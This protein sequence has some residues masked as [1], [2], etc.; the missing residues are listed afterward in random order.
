MLSW[1][2]SRAKSVK[3]GL[4]SL[5][6]AVL[7]AAWAPA[8]QD[9]RRS[10][11]GPTKNTLGNGLTWI[12][13][14]DRSSS[15][16]SL[17]F[18]IGGGQAAEPTG[19]GGLSY[20][21]ARM[22]VEI[23]DDDKLRELMTRSTRFSVVGL[24]DCVLI[25]IQCLSGNL[26]D[27]LRTTGKIMTDPLI[28]GLRIDA[29]KENMRYQG[30]SSLDDSI[31]AGH[32]AAMGAFFGPGGCGGPVWG[33]EASLDAIR[34]KDV[35]EFYESRVTGSNIT[36]SVVSDLEERT[37]A[38][39]LEKYFA[40]LKAGLP[41]KP[42]SPAVR[43]PETKEI[44]IDKETGETYL[45]LAFPL[46]ALS[47]RNFALAFLVDNVLSGGIGSRLW[48]LRF[49][50][51]LA[52]S[53]NAVV[54]QTA[55]QGMLEAYL[56]TSSGKLPSAQSALRRV[57]GELAERGLTG[58]ELEA[59]VTDSASTFLRMNETKEARGRNLALFEFRGLG[60]G[61]VR[62]LPEEMGKVSLDEI[63]AFLKAVLSPGGAVE[64]VIGPKAD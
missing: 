15:T 8:R 50:D 22:A 39:W 43:A 37:V 29:A 27:A 62:E 14:Q 24:E 34:K 42:V 26:E 55:G 35:A 7:A 54:T 13:E 52:Y 20:L 11:G 10:P 23:P 2:L 5:G 48:Q 51:K 17:F 31:S 41:L 56:E 59:A 3:R 60:R 57:V 33:T 1:P 18:V 40:G 47:A 61:F 16:T 38:G 44:R 46:P 6:L 36:V 30:K 9:S 19:L 58:E 45:G 64:V 63:N 32:A 49:L 53:F 25:G 4:L 12:Y 28:S 21:T